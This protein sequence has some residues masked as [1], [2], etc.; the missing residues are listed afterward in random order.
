M[1]Q[2]EIEVQSDRS[3][4]ADTAE[5]GRSFN[6]GQY[7][8]LSPPIFRESEVD[9]YF[10][11]FEKMASRMG[12]PEDKWSV[13][14]QSVLTGK[15]QKVYA[16]MPLQDSADYESVK[17]KILDAYEKVPEAY[18]QQVRG[19]VKSE[20][21]TF[22]EFATEKEQCFDRWVRSCRCENQYDKLREVFLIEEFVRKLT[23]E[24]R[25]YVNEKRV[26][27]LKEAATFA[28]EYA[29]THKTRSQYQPKV[30]PPFSGYRPQRAQTGQNPS[31]NYRP[32]RK[33]PV[34]DTRNSQLP[35]V[36]CAYCKIA[37]HTQ[38]E[39]WRLNG[40][41]GSYP[42]PVAATGL[43]P[44]GVEM[45][46]F[47]PLPVEVQKDFGPFVSES[48]VSLFDSPPTKIH[49]LRDTGAAQSLILKNVLP[50][51]EESYSGTSVLV[52]GVGGIQSIPLHKVVLES[53]L[54]PAGVYLVGVCDT[55]P[56]NGVSLLLGN[57]LAG[58]RVVSNPCMSDVP[59]ISKDESDLQDI[60][61]ECVVTRAT[62]RRQLA[63][64]PITSDVDLCL[65]DS[66]MADLR[67][68]PPANPPTEVVP[69]LAPGVL[70]AMTREQLIHEQQNDVELFA[71]AGKAV[72]ETESSKVAVCYYVLSG[73]LMLFLGMAGFYRKFCCNFSTVVAPLTDLLKKGTKFVW[74]EG[75]QAAFEKV[76]A[77][78]SHSPVLAAPD[79]SK[80]F[81]IAVDSCD[82]GTGSVLMQ[83]DDAGVDHP[84]C[85]YSKKFN[86]H[87]KNY[88][89]VEKEALGLIFALQH[90]EVYV[91]SS[92]TPVTVYTDHN[93][94]T[95]VH[96]MRTKKPKVVKVESG[97]SGLQHRY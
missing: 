4:Q 60:F 69:I 23:P 48:S 79:F 54:V 47:T 36:T 86:P 29:L 38:S 89:T 62:A 52:S 9:E 46:L 8:K 18:R 64:D 57:D 66:F 96:K 90:F 25:T 33:S 65:A 12:W 21:Q 32:Y 88:S 20:R 17:A 93:P 35:R 2:R 6:V 19:Q 87:Q 26:S 78:L 80:P 70:P 68:I 94:L 5:R 27:T 11:A 30:N 85:F 39:C 41:P 91:G 76:K 71:F 16:A 55:L 56:V 77:M 61:P 97:P 72:S 74:S 82:I 3:S 28:D 53:K 67:D 10:D 7:L 13:I 63:V 44:S 51:S 31:S 42:K 49:V 59:V 92:S 45:K 22:C 14:L 58:S 75:C 43:S 95:F 40:R 37:G 81:V 50:F 1:K 15:A 34:P 24:L 84:I 83:Q 73:L